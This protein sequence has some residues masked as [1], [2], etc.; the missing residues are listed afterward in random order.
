MATLDQ[1]EK[2]DRRIKLSIQLLRTVSTIVLGGFIGTLIILLCNIAI[3]KHIY[4][5]QVQ[6]IY[7]A[8]VA[9]LETQQRI[10]SEMERLLELDFPGSLTIE[11]R[12]TLDTI[13]SFIRWDSSV[14]GRWYTLISPTWELTERITDYLI[15]LGYQIDIESNCIRW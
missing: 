11:E 4:E 8:S 2:R 6:G 1:E 14:G 15:E 9:R 12:E 10:N 3:S 7:S 5:T 13:I